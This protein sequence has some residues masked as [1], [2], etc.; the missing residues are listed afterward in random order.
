MV[1]QA[2]AELWIGVTDACVLSRSSADAAGQITIID[3][4]TLAVLASL[5]AV[6]CAGVRDKILRVTVDVGSCTG[7][8]VKRC[9][10]WTRAHP[11]HIT[12]ALGAVLAARISPGV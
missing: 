3:A 8:L 5:S 11:V 9:S 6:S 7:C 4:S 10:A 2:E 12:P 1:V